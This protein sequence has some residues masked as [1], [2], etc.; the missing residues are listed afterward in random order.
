MKLIARW[1]LIALILAGLAAGA[2]A[3]QARVLAESSMP[4]PDLET[5]CG[6]GSASDNYG[7]TYPLQQLH[8]TVNWENYLTLDTVDDIDRLLDGLNEDSIAQTMILLLPQEEVGIPVNCAVHFLRYMQL[9]LPEGER[10]DNGFVFLVIINSGGIDVH[11]GVGLGLPALTAQGL[12]PINRLAEDTYDQT[13]SLDEAVLA[14]VRAYESYAR[15]K[16]EP[17]YPSE[18]GPQTS[19]E[20]PALPDLGALPPI[21]ICV[22]LCLLCIG[23]IVLLMI[24]NFLTRLMRHGG[25]S[26]RLPSS[27]WTPGPRMPSPRWNPGPSIPRTRMPTF[28]GGSGSGRSGRGN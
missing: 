19:V 22:G 15:S 23:M 3:P 26:Y 6:S 17:Y 12:T 21:A 28:R 18:S 16:Y 27:G 10:K 24:V 1:I 2:S 8:W 13:G 9:G 20:L 5:L 25:G 14:L 4:V 11:Y 7:L